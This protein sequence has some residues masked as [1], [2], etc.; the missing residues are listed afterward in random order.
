MLTTAVLAY[1][2]DASRYSVKKTNVYEDGSNRQT[3]RVNAWLNLQRGVSGGGY[4]YFRYIDTYDINENN[5]T[6]ELN[7]LS[8]RWGS[9]Y[10]SM[11]LIEETNETIKIQAH[12][13]FQ[14]NREA[15]WYNKEVRSKAVM[16]ITYSKIPLIDDN[17]TIEDFIMIRGTTVDDVS[18]Q[19]GM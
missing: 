6:N 17:K 12:G 14:H 16:N 13:I 9:R 1:D 19:L 8:V 11:N 2:R 4:M 10:G 3:S 5:I 18:F 15:V 7:Q